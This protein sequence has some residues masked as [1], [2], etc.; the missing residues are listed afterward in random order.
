MEELITKRNKDVILFFE[1]LEEIITSL[2]STFEETR[3]LFNAERY[4]T[5][6]EV[7]GILKVSRRTLQDYRN[8]GIISYILLGGKVLY[9]ESDMEKTLNNNYIKAF[10]E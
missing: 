9:K 7:A 3:P 2:E 6:K 5:D 8:Q 10:R 1:G 4:L